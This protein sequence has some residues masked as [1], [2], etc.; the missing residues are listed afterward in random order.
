MGNR[1]IYVETVIAADLERVWAATQDPTQHVRWDVRFSGD[2]EQH[3]PNP[4]REPHHES[5]PHGLA[6]RRQRGRDRG[7]MDG[8]DVGAVA[9]ALVERADSVGRAVVRTEASTPV[10]ELRAAVRKIARAGASRSAPG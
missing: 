2:G 3:A 5:L 10:D 1:G 4:P 7:T 8:M 6:P 9:A